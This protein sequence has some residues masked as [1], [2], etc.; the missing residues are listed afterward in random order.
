MVGSEEYSIENL[1]LSTRVKG[2]LQSR[3]DNGRSEE[4][5]GEGADSSDRFTLEEG[6]L[7]AGVA[8]LKW[9]DCGWKSES[10]ALPVSKIGR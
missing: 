8:F 3:G 6:G 2:G 5:E 9:R 7:C 10:E 4:F 1:G